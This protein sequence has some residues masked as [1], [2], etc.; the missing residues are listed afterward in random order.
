MVAFSQGLI[1]SELSMAHHDQY[2]YHPLNQGDEDRKGVQVPNDCG[3]PID[4][5]YLTASSW[6]LPHGTADGHESYENISTPN[7]DEYPA[8]EYHSA[9]S[10]SDS[11]EMPSLPCADVMR[12]GLY[13]PPTSNVTPSDSFQSLSMNE[14]ANPI[15]RRSQYFSEAPPIAPIEGLSSVSSE[16]TTT[17]TYNPESR[18]VPARSAFIMFS[19]ATREEIMRRAGP[20]GK[21]C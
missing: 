12:T 15:Y 2:K 6:L 17:S 7:G 4:R 21:V 19:E 13:L 14:H 18:P 1:L 10:G 20:N 9:H 8:Q 11:N 16:S 5:S 3:S